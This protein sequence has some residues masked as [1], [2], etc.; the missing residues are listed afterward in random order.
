MLGVEAKRSVMY[1]PECVVVVANILPEVE[2][3]A[4]FGSRLSPDGETSETPH[5][6]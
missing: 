2:C 3:R 4:A 5:R 1:H 6:R